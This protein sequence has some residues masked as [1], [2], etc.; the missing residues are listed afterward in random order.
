MELKK[1]RDLVSS[2]FSPPP[3]DF[4]NIEC[5][6]FEQKLWVKLTPVVNFTKILCV[7]F[8]YKSL[9]CSFFVLTFL[10]CTFF[11]ARISAQKLQW[12]EH[13]GEI[14]AVL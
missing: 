1:E 6:A 3:I 5:A 13:V 9:A 14:D 12:R 10:V 4:T 2:L 11:D 7:N 8:L